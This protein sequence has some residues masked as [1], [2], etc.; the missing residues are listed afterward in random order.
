MRLNHSS[1]VPANWRRMGGGGQR[2]GGLRG[3][4]ENRAA[5]LAVVEGSGC[6][7]TGGRG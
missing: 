2:I 4:I 3:V 5:P 7:R 1:D 6:D